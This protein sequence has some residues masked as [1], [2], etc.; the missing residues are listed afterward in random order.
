MN[1]EILKITPDQL[2]VYKELESNKMAWVAFWFVMPLFTIG[3]L[4]FLASIFLVHE[5]TFP[6]SIAGGV[7]FLLGFP[8]HRIISYLFPSSA[9]IAKRGKK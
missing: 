4:A 3:F 2:I 5:Q 8:V 6:K 9:R 7:D 1:E